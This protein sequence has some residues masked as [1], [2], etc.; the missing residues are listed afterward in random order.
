MNHR[1]G[2]RACGN[3]ENVLGALRVP[4]LVGRESAHVGTYG[5]RV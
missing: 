2:S 1:N 3:V 4:V 5:G